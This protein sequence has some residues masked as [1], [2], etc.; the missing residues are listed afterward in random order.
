M[1]RQTEQHGCSN[2]TQRCGCEAS[3]TQWPPFQDTTP[4]VVSAETERTAGSIIKTQRRTVY[5]DAA[6]ESLKTNLGLK[7]WEPVHLVTC[8]Y[9]NGCAD[10]LTTELS[11]FLALDV[12]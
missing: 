9:G 12:F 7:Y 6:E 1:L 2:M 10:I 11:F 4:A 8:F 5:G 3:D